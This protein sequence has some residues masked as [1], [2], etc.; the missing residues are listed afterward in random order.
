MAAVIS[1]DE[2]LL[3][4]NKYVKRHLLL[5]NGFSIACVPTIF[6]YG[7][8]FSKADFSAM[9]EVKEIF[10]ILKTQDFELVVNALEKSSL[11]IPVYNA[12][13]TKTANK[14][15][16][17]AQKLKEVLIQTLAQN[18]PAYPAIIEEERY[19][20]CLRFLANFLDKE[21]C[22]YTLNYDLLLYWTTM[23]GLERKL[24]NTL[25]LDGF[26]KDADFENGEALVS[27]YVTWQGDSSAHRQNIHYLHGA[28]HL[29]DR[30]ADIE[31]FTWVNTGISLIDQ[32]RNALAAN[33]FPLFVAEGESPKKME[34]I[35]HSGYLYHSY[36]SFSANM[37]VTPRNGK[38]CLFTYGVSFGE[39]DEHVLKKIPQGKIGHLFISI[40]GDPTTTANKQIIAFAERLK[41]KR[42]TNDLEVTYYDAGSAKVWGN[43]GEVYEY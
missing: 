34:K 41:R 27:D 9:P 1:F 29:Y 43:I 35:A 14:M 20:A 33:R 23:Y 7:S 18:H 28:L 8:L 22:V 32:S 16:A 38:N 3:A 5:G 4:S 17:H 25:P 21:S 39:N 26:G 37:K 10:E 24:I 12:K 6:T 11:M 19:K 40:F 13:R 36:K 30:G 2:A 31:K 42:R 15:Y